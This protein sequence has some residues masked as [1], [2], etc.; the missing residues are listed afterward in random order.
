MARNYEVYKLNGLV[1]FN[2]TFILHGPSVRPFLNSLFLYE[3]QWPGIHVRFRFA[4]P[5]QWMT[6]STDL[7][8]VSSPHTW[9]SMTDL[10]E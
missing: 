1:N 4:H 7:N 6:H 5:K 9:V 10:V 2:G 8:K 3:T